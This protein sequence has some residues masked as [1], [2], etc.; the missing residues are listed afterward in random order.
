MKQKSLRQIA[1]ELGVSAS[2]LSKVKTGKRPASERVKGVLSK[3][4]L[5]L[6]IEESKI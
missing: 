2:Y 3:A 5:E 6:M 4:T 1:S